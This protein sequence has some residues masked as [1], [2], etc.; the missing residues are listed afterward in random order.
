[1]PSVFIKVA[2]LFPALGSKPRGPC[3]V[4]DRINK[5]VPAGSRP[6][7]IETV[8]SDEDLTNSQAAQI[9]RV[10]DERGPHPFTQFEI[11]PHAQ[12]RMD[13]R[14]I[15]VS[16]LKATLS[17]FVLQVEEWRRTRDPKFEQLFR[18]VREY[19]YLDPKSGLT[20][21]FALNE[22]GRNLV[23][24]IV[25]VFWKGDEDPKYPA[26]G[27]P[28][29]NAGYRAPAGDLAG[30]RTFVDE[31]PAKGIQDSLGDTIHHPP[32]ES[33]KSDR[34]RALPQRTDTKENLTEHRK[35]PPVYNTP[36]PSVPMSDRETR[37]PGEPG[38]S[39][40][41]RV[42]TP[43][44]PGE[45]YG[46][47]YKENVYPRRTASDDDLETDREAGLFPSY[48]QR[49]RKHRGKAKRYYQR[50]YRRNKSKI[51]RRS[52]LRYRKVR[53]NPIFKR[54]RK[55]RNDP[56]YRDRFR[57]LEY[58]GKRDLRR[59]SIEA[60]D[61]DTGFYH[62]IFGW[63]DVVG[64]DADS[65]RI[66]VHLDGENNL[67]A[68]QIGTFMASVVF[69]SDES[70]EEMFDLL[71]RV[72]DSP[73]ARTVAATFYRE[74]FTKGYNLDPGE[75][76]QDLGAPGPESPLRL[77][78]PDD[79]HHDRKPAERPDFGQVDN[80]PGSAKV[81]PEGHGFVNRMASGSPSSIRVAARMAEILDGAAPE[82]LSRSRL[83]K[84]RKKKVNS[85]NLF[86]VFAVPGS[87][88]EPY[89]VRVK[90]TR[91]K[92]NVSDVK[93]MDL[94]LSCS[95]DFWRWQGPEHWAK[96]GDYLYGKP[97][98]T[99][100]RPT[101]KDPR[102]KHRVCKH[103]AAVLSTIKTWDLSTPRRR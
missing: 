51:K 33:P 101:E 76:A 63:G 48:S 88:G 55:L 26:E 46:H 92:A 24:S 86:F 43:G 90:M 52:K 28:T 39:D 53:N 75:G 40:K 98:G 5:R 47:P 16:D 91:P 64:L 35:G 7:L 1:M 32:G 100:A 21:V 58:G 23:P 29:R 2:D 97:R 57:R 94:K 41:I 20:L 81:I 65:N 85:D 22:R 79:E 89:T 50:Y 59:G 96:V 95:C 68:I 6:D 80:N 73:D 27:C 66:L 71:D 102:A 49:Q 4:V 99:A 37:T 42:R 77:D 34:E 62:P 70:T 56:R 10:E 19:R 12:Y 83:I 87:K 36:G 74:V 11:R 93:K 67:T 103:V 25:T 78:Y 14:G 84:P 15:T 18:G 8:K 9:Y 72:Y 60:L 30:V 13:L 69:D 31:K 82:V 61:L 38:Q 3:R 54:K 44:V 17:R 45:E